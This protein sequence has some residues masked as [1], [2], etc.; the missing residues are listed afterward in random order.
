[1]DLYVA[2]TNYRANLFGAQLV[3]LARYPDFRIKKI[4]VM[5]HLFDMTLVAVG[6]LGEYVGSL[7]EH[8]QAIADALD[9][10]FT[11]SWG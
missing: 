1:M 6:Q 9:E 7:S 3:Y 2:K 5:L 4:D 10:L 8:G 11:L